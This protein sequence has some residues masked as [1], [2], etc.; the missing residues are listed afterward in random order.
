M[1][2]STEHEPAHLP[3][4]LCRQAEAVV[5]AR[6]FC[7]QDTINKHKWSRGRSIMSL[8][9]KATDVASHADALITVI[10]KEALV[11][12][13]HLLPVS[14]MKEGVRQQRRRRFGSAM[15]RSTQGAAD[16]LLR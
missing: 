1:L 5:L 3:F 4:R 9:D 13:T 11:S 10:E 14:S 15:W 12:L 7:G 6:Y 8:C 2:V 16:R